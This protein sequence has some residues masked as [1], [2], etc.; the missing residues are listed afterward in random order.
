MNYIISEIKKLTGKNEVILTKRCNESIKIAIKTCI[1][2]LKNKNKDKNIVFLMQEEGGWI[3][4][5]QFAK[6]S[7][8]LKENIIRLKMHKGKIDLNNLKKYSFCILIMHSMPGYS[9]EEN[10][11]DIMDICTNNKILLINDCS[12][13]INTEKA[14]YGNITVCSFGKDKPINCGTGGFIATNSEVKEEIKIQTNIIEKENILYTKEAVDLIDLDKLKEQLKNLKNKLINWEAISQKIKKEL[15]QKYTILNEGK[16]GINVLIEFKNLNERETLIK[17]CEDN[18]LQYTICPRYIRTN[19][20][21]I[22][23]EI[24]RMQAF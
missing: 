16:Q 21:A 6:K 18:K 11:K 13:S 23:I 8:I 19:K 9:Y 17:Y 22:S 4:Y 24:K 10:M 20:N 12:G 14:K 15:K 3:T 1:S 7:G 2:I 5:E